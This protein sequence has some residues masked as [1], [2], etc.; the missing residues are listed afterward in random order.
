MKV[1]I[2]TGIL[3]VALSVLAMF[4][5]FTPLFGILLSFL[6]VIAVFEIERAA[7]ISN[8]F[9]IFVSLLFAAVVPS[10]IEYDLLE[11][12]DVSL[13]VVLIVYLILMLLLML[14]QYKKTRFEHVTM[15]FFASLAVP[16][17]FS[18]LL[19]IRD[20]YLAFP[21]SFEKKHGFY[22]V[23]LVLVCS[24]LTDTFAYFIGVNFGKHKMCPVISPKKTVEGAIGG[25]VLTL[26]SNLIIL[27]IFNNFIFAKELMPLWVIVPISVV[28]SVVSMLGDLS[29]STIKR[30]Y[31]IK[32]FGKF[33]PGHGGVMDRFDSALFV[34]PFVYATITIF[35][36]IKL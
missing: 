15:A 10:A 8:R 23:A 22:L 30:N 5:L 27:Y 18:S 13:S 4:Y 20:V 19:L 26:V 1:R 25:I 11:K 9:I 6:T 33:F 24:W 28:L 21:N 35:M 2:I 31:D 17:A 36:D 32:D 14:A 29:A 12:L 16:F 3:G 7:Q 34:A